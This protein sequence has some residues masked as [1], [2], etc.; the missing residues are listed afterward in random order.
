MK[1]LIAIICCLIMLCG[2]AT[3]TAPP[4]EVEVN[5]SV[6]ESSSEESSLVEESKP[7]EVLIDYFPKQEL[8]VPESIKILAIGNSFS[9][10]AMTY[11][12]QFLEDAGVQEIVLGNLY[13]GGCSIKQ[14]A[15]NVQLHVA[16][17]TYYKNTNGTWTQEPIKKVEYGLLDEDWDIITMQQASGVSGKDTSYSRL[18]DLIKYVNENKTN[19]DAKLWWHMTWA[20]AQNSTHGEFVNYNNDQITMYESIVNCVRTIVGPTESFSGLIPCGTAMQNV[21][22]GLGD[23]VTVDGYHANDFPG[24][25]TLSMTW[26]CALTGCSPSDLTWAPDWAEPQMVETIKTAVAHALENPYEVS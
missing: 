11:L 17:Y 3:K 14:H 1:K 22:M 18:K 12:Y 6:Q 21:R 8:T 16:A 4:S 19:P 2:C 7:E 9:V 10:D 25:Y 5:S 13:M 23:N 20:Y 26:A 15:D 24:K